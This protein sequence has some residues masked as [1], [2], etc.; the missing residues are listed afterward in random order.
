MNG[1]GALVDIGDLVSSLL[2]E[3][4]LCSLEA[5]DGAEV[6][7]DLPDNLSPDTGLA[8]VLRKSV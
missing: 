7:V 3:Q 5:V 8:I 1:D 2:Q 4:L 6:G